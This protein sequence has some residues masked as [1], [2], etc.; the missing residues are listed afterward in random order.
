MHIH[1]ASYQS[2]RVYHPRVLQEMLEKRCPLNVCAVA[3]MG[4]AGRGT[5]V[6]RHQEDLELLVLVGGCIGDGSHGW[7]GSLIELLMEYCK[8]T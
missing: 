6:R 3:P 8:V 7:I 1:K 5:M 4:S 2:D